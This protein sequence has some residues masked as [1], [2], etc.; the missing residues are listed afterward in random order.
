MVA[1]Y[2]DG[3]ERSQKNTCLAFLAANFCE[4]SKARQHAIRSDAETSPSERTLLTHESVLERDQR[5]ADYHP[6]VVPLFKHL[7]NSVSL[8]NQTDAAGASECANQEETI[9]RSQR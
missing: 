3:F 8:E 7:K 4:I 5:G 1:L 9:S 2:A 6:V